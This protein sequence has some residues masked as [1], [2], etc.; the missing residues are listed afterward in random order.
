ME[1]EEDQLWQL[2]QDI[3]LTKQ[4]D[5]FSEEDLEQALTQLKKEKI[6]R[7]KLKSVLNSTQDLNETLNE[8]NFDLRS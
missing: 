7:M 3:S 6:A 4:M 1:A 2:S 5:F 8:E